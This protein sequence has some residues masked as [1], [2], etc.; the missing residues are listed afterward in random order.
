MHLKT[1]TSEYWTWSQCLEKIKA[2]ILDENFII[3]V[4]NSLPTEYEIQVSK[5]EQ[6]FGSA[7]NP[8][9]IQDVCNKLNLNF[10]ELKCQAMEQLETDQPLMAFCRY[11]GKCT[12]CSKFR[13]KLTECCPKARNSKQERRKNRSSK[14]KSK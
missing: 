11:K 13:H 3:Q 2:D 4:L 5:L 6:C 8:L 10:A 7:T 9:T 1:L 14:F 12:S